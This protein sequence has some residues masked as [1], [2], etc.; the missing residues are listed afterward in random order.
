M[1][2]FSERTVWGQMGIIFSLCAT[3]GVPAGLIVIT[4]A[5]AKIDSKYAT[6][7]DLET[8]QEQ[9]SRQMASVQESVEENTGEVKVALASMDSLSMMV[10]DIQI[11]TLEDTISRL[12]ATRSEWSRA[13]EQIYREKRRALEDSE[14]QRQ[15]LYGRILERSGR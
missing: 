1:T 3:M 15:E 2:K 9:L 5:D 8:L 6:D 10:L 7:T 14:R 12:D 4:A 11:A 13:E